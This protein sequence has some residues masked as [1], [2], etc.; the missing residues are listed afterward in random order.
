VPRSGEVYQQI[1]D[2]RREQI[3]RTAAEVFARR[4]VASTRINDIAEAAGISQGLLY[5]YFANREEVFAALLER[6]V[7]ETIRQVHSALEYPGTPWEQLHWL[8]GQLLLGMYEQPNFIP[9]F[10]QAPALSGR[11]PGMLAELGT[12]FSTV[13]R[14]LIVAGQA[15]G[16]VVKREPEQ[17]VLLYLCCLQGLAAGMTFY[18]EN[19]LAHFP[20]ADAVLQLFK[21]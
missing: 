2:E 13:L 12:A 7:Q 20:D 11:V 8:T 3:L 4:G 19:L 9:L 14:Q 21:P 15:A 5:R 18:G 17:L 16:Q 6:L 10:S 1:R